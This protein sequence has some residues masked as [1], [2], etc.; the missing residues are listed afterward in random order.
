MKNTIKQRTPQEEQ[1]SA[2]GAV[3][4]G[5]DADIRVAVVKIIP[6]MRWQIPKGIIDPGE[7]AEQAA[8]REVREEA[9]VETELIAPIETIDYWFSVNRD[10]GRVKI[11]K[12]VQFFLMRYTAGDVADHDHEVEEA[13][14]VPVDEALEM[15]AFEQERAVVRRGHEMYTKL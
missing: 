15:L 4:R 13:R 14:W 8:R 10:G 6:D 9:G 7:T 5:T 3:F 1:F 11:H 12:F 2:G